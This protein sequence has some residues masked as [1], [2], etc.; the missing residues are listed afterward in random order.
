MVSLRLGDRFT[1]YLPDC[2]TF[3][4]LL[5]KAEAC[6]GVVGAWDYVRS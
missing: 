3:A 2:L 4:V 1:L 5:S 6:S